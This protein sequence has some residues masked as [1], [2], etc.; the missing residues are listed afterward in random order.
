MDDLADHRR[1]RLPE[2]GSKEAAA[3]G[4]AD[5]VNGSVMVTVATQDHCTDLEKIFAT[6]D[7]RHIPKIGVIHV[8][9]DVG[10]EVSHYFDYGFRKIILIEANPES[11]KTLE[12]RF[13]HHPNVRLFNYAICDK[14]GIIDFHIHTSRSGSTEPAS[15]LPMKRFKEIVKTLHTPKTIKVPATTLDSLFD[16]NGV[17]PGEYNFIN[18]DIQGAELLAFAGA[19]KL[20]PSIDAIVSEVNLVEMYE[21]GALEGDIVALLARHGFEKR[22]AIY[23]TLYD[24][25]STFPA[26]G[27]C[28]FV[29]RD[30][31]QSRTR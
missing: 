1:F 17:A 2:S 30:A 16:K 4:V 3:S 29:R 24:D 31:A 18:I 20:M 11:Y 13:G 9:A 14:E 6:D 25:A 26:W 27:E 7:L 19:T 23:H 28:L 12:L 21:G 10:Q 8:G 5:G 22:Y 15:I